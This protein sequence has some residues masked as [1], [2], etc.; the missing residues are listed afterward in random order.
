MIAKANLARE[1]CDWHAAAQLYRSALDRDR[2]LTHIW[3]QLG[4][5][6]KESGCSID[7][8]EAYFEAFKL[9][10]ADTGLLGWLYGVASRLSLAD[11]RRLI[12]EIFAIQGLSIPTGPTERLAA[13]CATEHPDLVFDASDLI[14]YFFRARRPTGI[15]RVQ[16][17]IIR[18]ALLN[19]NVPSAR[20]CCA[21]EGEAGWVE[22]SHEQFKHLTDLATA[23]DEYDDLVWQKALQNFNVSLVLGLPFEFS[24]GSIII[25]LG[26]SWWLQNYFLQI[27]N[28]KSQS[29]V[30]YIPFIHDLIPVLAPQHCVQG[31]VE[32]FNSW[33]LGVFHHAE[34][35]LVN[36]QAT[37]KDLIRVAEMLGHSVEEGSVTVIPLDGT[38]P[39]A[40]ACDDDLKLA[41][42]NLDKD[43][44]VL[45]VSTIESRKG[46]VVALH[47]W[48]RLLEEYGERTPRLVCV[49]NDGWLNQQF[50]DLLK[51][52][53]RLRAHATLLSGIADDELKALYR[54]CLLT[55]YPSTYEGWGLPVTE[56]L[57]FGK[58][59]IAADNS[60]LPEAGGQ[61]A[62]YFTTGDS[63]QLSELV[64]EYSFN[65]TARIAQEKKILETFAPRPWSDVSNQIIQAVLDPAS[66]S[67]FLESDVAPF[68]QPGRRLEFGRVRSLSAA[69]NMGAASG[70]TLRFGSGW[71]I[72][73]AQGCWVRGHKAELR[74][75][76]DTKNGKC[77]MA[78]N[79]YA[80]HSMDWA[81]MINGAIADQGSVAGQGQFRSSFDLPNI[82]QSLSIVISNRAEPSKDRDSGDMGL[83]IRG[84]LITV[85]NSN[86]DLALN[87]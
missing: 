81:V 25:N 48:Q 47:A 84:C 63:K 34:R 29:K 68:V 44:F 79:F 32:D 57:S 71:H 59:V 55:I 10:P 61:S 15:Q 24:R 43:P 5:M 38:F 30:E 80:L 35:F 41:K 9:D 56:A 64:A 72:P 65:E 19:N 66:R 39:S 2:E 26:T 53:P 1:S 18:A 75:R 7:A 54:N 51:S 78:L 49:G 46:H 50:Y 23:G 20:I 52:D 77:Q 40:L 76:L 82:S 74:L 86:S 6:F 69:N 83:A 36:S 27:R 45:F 4:H 62:D 58:I 28:A 37:K 87:L 67:E 42:L 85:K 13:Q 11:R 60:S 3:V 31:L 33:I 17:E 70:E 22:V 73:D 16:I 21:V 8:S 12:G 14:N